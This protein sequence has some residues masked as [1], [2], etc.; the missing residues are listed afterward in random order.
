MSTTYTSSDVFERDGDHAQ[1]KSKNNSLKMV[2]SSLDFARIE[3][4]V[5]GLNSMAEL[6]V[7]KHDHVEDK[8]SDEAIYLTQIG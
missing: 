2:V 5:H 3:L 8:S 6:V 1:N 7:V 4:I